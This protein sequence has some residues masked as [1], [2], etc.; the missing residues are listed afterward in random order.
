VKQVLNCHFIDKKM[1]N[2]SEYTI[3]E[4]VVM[5]TWAHERPYKGEDNVR[6]QVLQWQVR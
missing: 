4:Q 1:T 3:E 5:R 2:E 6:F